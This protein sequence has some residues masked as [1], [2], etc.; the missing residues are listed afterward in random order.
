VEML[1]MRVRKV[2]QPPLKLREPYVAEAEGA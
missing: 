1:N 2:S